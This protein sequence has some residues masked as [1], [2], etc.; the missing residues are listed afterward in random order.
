MVATNYCSSSSTTQKSVEKPPLPRNQTN[1]AGLYN[2]GATCYLNALIQ[3]LC[4]TPEFRENLF[5]LSAEDLNFVPLSSTA[6]ITT[7]NQNLSPK[8]RKIPVELQRL[9]AKLLLLNEQACSSTKLTDSFGWTAENAVLTFQ[10]QDIHECNKI[11]FQAIEDSLIRTKE[12]DLI[13]N[14]YR[15]T[16]VNCTQCKK[17]KSTHKVSEDYYDLPIIVQGCSNLEQS[18][19]NTFQF[20]EDLT[21]DNQYRCSTCQSLCDAEKTCKIRRL[22]PIL[23]L[24]LQ[25]FTWDLKT[26]KRIK[27]TTRY[28]FPFE[29]DLK[30]YCEDTLKD[31][32]YELFAVAIHKGTPYSGHYYAYIKDIDHIGAWTRPLNKQAPKE[33]IT[34]STA[35]AK[36]ASGII[37]IDPVQES[38]EE[39]KRMMIE[40]IKT[41]ISSICDKNNPFAKTNAILEAN[42]DNSWRSNRSNRKY[43]TFLKFLRD[44]P[45]I[46]E[47]TSDNQSVRIRHEAIDEDVM[48]VDEPL[49]NGDDDDNQMDTTTPVDDQ[50]EDE[51][52]FCFDDS[53][54]TCVTKQMIEKH[55]T[56]N[57]CAYMLFYRNMNLRRK[58]TKISDNHHH[59]TNGISQ[60]FIPQWLVDEIDELNRVLAKQRL[61]I[62]ICLVYREVYENIQNQ[63]LT[64]IYPGEWFQ[65]IE[66]RLNV[67][68]QES[69]LPAPFGEHTLDK[70]QNVNDFMLTLEGLFGQSCTFYVAKKLKSGQF[71]GISELSVCVNDTTLGK[72]D[73]YTYRNIIVF[74]KVDMLKSVLFGEDYEPIMLKVVF[75]LSDE[76]PSTSLKKDFLRYIPKC[77]TIKELKQQ[78]FNEYYQIGNDSLSSPKTNE[79]QQQTLRQIRLGKLNLEEKNERRKFREFKEAEESHTIWDIGLRDNDTIGIDNRQTFTQ[80]KWKDAALSTNTTSK[81]CLTIRNAYDDKK[82]TQT[83]ASNTSIGEVK[84]VAVSAFG[85]SINID[86]CRLHLDDDTD[87]ALLPRILASIGIYVNSLV[88]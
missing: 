80:S 9:F 31:T 32:N 16:T 5:R 59:Q 86:E 41:I 74:E 52:W 70:R 15:G 47:L 13:K 54:V 79:K 81:L 38:N 10:H 36:K 26:G 46:F 35:S 25:R 50:N 6:A 78:L 30:S 75:A 3:T 82:M 21:G 1:L 84:L 17:C 67:N 66:G 33:R 68:N 12:G 61:I 8:V 7:T 20:S 65:V 49:N 42:T 27:K 2:Q 58:S 57:E 4:F 28:D 34:R 56:Q 37:V 71:H 55:F 11:V 64:T 48:D 45:K 60:C 43:G 18:L 39:E 14:L 77:V 85:L 88:K 51:H 69:I 76:Q 40:T 83:Y 22:P 53:S 62:C 29:I 87:E 73:L 24:S 72:T 19:A 23:T 63:F 44:H